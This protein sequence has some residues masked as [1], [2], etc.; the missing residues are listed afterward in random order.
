MRPTWI[1]SPG[2]PTLGGGTQSRPPRGKEQRRVNDPRHRRQRLRRQPR[3]AGIDRCGASSRG[4]HALAPRPR[5][6][7][8]GASPRVPAPTSRPARATSPTRA[9]LAAALDGRRRRPPPRR[10]PARLE[11]RRGPAPRQHRGHAQ[12]DRR[13]ARGRHPAVR[14]PG[15][16]RRDRRPGAPLRIV[17]GEGRTP[18]RRQRPQLD[19]HQAVAPVRRAR[20]LL[21]RHRH[22]RPHVARRRPDPGRARGAASSR[23]SSATSPGSSLASSTTRGPYGQAYELGGPAYATY[24]EIV[25]EVLRGMGARRGDPADAAAAHPPRRP[26]VGGASGCP[27]R[28]R[29]T[30]SASSDSTTGPTSTPCRRASGSSRGRW[31]GTSGTCAARLSDQEP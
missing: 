7:S 27:S 4:A 25:E 6:A 21:Q 1:R 17:E 23:S 2:D 12:P 20:R 14:P 26:G 28:S 5:T 13:D 9:S 29:A 16:A 19:D 15:R 8:C 24:R 11:R 18:R 30:S 31:P 10:H 3:R 22:A